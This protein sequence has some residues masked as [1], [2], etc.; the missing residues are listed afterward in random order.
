LRYELPNGKNATISSSDWSG[1]G[2]GVTGKMWDFQTC[3][4]LVVR[5]GFSD[6]S[7][8]IPRKWTLQWLTDHCQNRFGATPQPFRLMDKW[9]F[10]DLVGNGGSYILFTNG[11]HDGWSV[12][13]YLEDLSDTIVTVNIA[14]GAH[15]SDLGHVFPLSD[16]KKMAR[17]HEEIKKVL[18][19]W[20]VDLYGSGSTHSKQNHSSL[21]S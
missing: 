15:H 19:G 9:G 7:M 12:A 17:A 16:T 20:L 18:A 11:L 1:V 21:R 8:F 4:E 2:D 6:K 3:T 5:A 13:S 10:E 14:D